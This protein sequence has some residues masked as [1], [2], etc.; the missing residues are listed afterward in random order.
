MKN[1][2]LIS[3]LFINF[4]LHSRQFYIWADKIENKLY[5][6][7]RETETLNQ[8]SLINIQKD[9][10]PSHAYRIGGIVYIS[11]FIVTD[12]HYHS[13]GERS[14][15]SLWDVRDNNYREIKVSN[16][17]SGYFSLTGVATD[18]SK[19]QIIFGLINVDNWEVTPNSDQIH[20]FKWNINSKTSPTKI[21]YS[22]FKNLY[23]MNS[24]DNSL[25][26]IPNK[27]GIETKYTNSDYVFFYNGKM[28]VWAHEEKRYY[29]LR[30]IPDFESK[31]ADHF[32]KWGE[33]PNRIT[34][35]H[36]KYR[37]MHF[38]SV[39]GGRSVK[40]AR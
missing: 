7:D 14:R 33:S 6:F 32:I 25:D 40:M 23:S 1:I 31:N 16:L 30:S 22:E 37:R 21:S 11:N 3:L 13:H 12:Y 29:T 8:Q 18:Q 20:E 26:P 34:D 27:S 36:R 17:V 38:I 24:Y 35:N 10:R 9:S 15:I 39:D 2:I 5:Y 4:N 19:T 28:E